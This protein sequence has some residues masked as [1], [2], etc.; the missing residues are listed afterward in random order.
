[1]A[2]DL[3]TPFKTEVL[4]PLVTLVV[5]GLI[6]VAPFVLVTAEYVPEVSAFWQTHAHAF[7]VVIALVTLAAGFIIDD[8]GTGV[9][10]WVIDRRLKRKLRSDCDEDVHGATWRAY[11]KLRLDDEIVGQRYLRTKFTQLKFELSMCLSLVVFA[12]G[13]T[14][15]DLRHPIWSW[16]GLIAIDATL[17]GSSGLFLWGASITA[18]LL[19]ETRV[20]ILESLKGESVRTPAPLSGS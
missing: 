3:A 20:I 17:L 18:E 9:E 16:P 6:A 13:I 14:W 19:H 4:R 15:L 8:L 10:K 1:V 11:L 5:P 2:V 12:G 7:A